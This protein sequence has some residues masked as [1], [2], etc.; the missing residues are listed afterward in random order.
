MVPRM[1]SMRLLWV[2]LLVALA[3]G[4]SVAEQDI[5]QVGDQF[6]QGIQGRGRLVPNDPTTDS[7]GSDYR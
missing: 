7:F 2:L 5:N 6:Q 4:C 1:K 3:G